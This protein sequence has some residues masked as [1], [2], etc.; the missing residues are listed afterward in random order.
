MYVRTYI[1]TYYKCVCMYVGSTRH[2]KYICMYI[3]T[4]IL[5][6]LRSTLCFVGSEKYAWYPYSLDGVASHHVESYCVMLSR[7]TSGKC[8]SGLSLNSSTASRS[9]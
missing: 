9:N 5:N 3:H 1:H 6:I 7:I 2:N 8:V 4:H